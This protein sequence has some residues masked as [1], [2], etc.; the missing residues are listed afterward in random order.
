MAF[1]Y[2][3]LVGQRVLQIR[4]SLVDDNSGGASTTV[5]RT[6]SGNGWEDADPACNGSALSFPIVETGSKIVVTAY[7]QGYTTDSNGNNMTVSH[8]NSAGS[9]VTY[10]GD[11][12]WSRSYNGWTGSSNISR[13]LIFDHGLNAGDTFEMKME[14]GT[15]TSGSM[16]MQGYGTYLSVIGMVAMEIGA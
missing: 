3:G 15:W 6:A 12:A 9:W 10:R 5:N 13:T 14:H 4:S 7:T 11:D 2:S 1:G 16:T 8:K